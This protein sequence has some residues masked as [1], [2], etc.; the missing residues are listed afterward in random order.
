MQGQQRGENEGRNKE[1]RINLG[2]VEPE[3]AQGHPWAAGGLDVSV[4]SKKDASEEKKS[5]LKKLSINSIRVLFPS[6]LLISQDVRARQLH[7]VSD[8]PR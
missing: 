1:E 4:E 6:A 2:K 3:H 5:H 8:N 7:H